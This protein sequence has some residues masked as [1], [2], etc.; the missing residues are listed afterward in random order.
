MAN[1][2][3]GTGKQYEEKPWS[4]GLLSP[5]A[6]GVRNHSDMAMSGEELVSHKR[7]SRGGR[8]RGGHVIKKIWTFGRGKVQDT[9]F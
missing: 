1:V 9:S 2:R 8:L 5:T 6:G 3:R 4:P 7:K